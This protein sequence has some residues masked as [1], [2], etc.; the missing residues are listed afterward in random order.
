M[1]IFYLLMALLATGWCAFS[2]HSLSG[3]VLTN[4]GAPLDGAHIHIEN[5]HGTSLPDGTYSV[6]GIATGSH[7]VVISFVGYVSLDTIVD[8]HKNE[9]LNANLKPEIIELKEVVL[10]EHPGGKDTAPI[11]KL[12]AQ[13]LEKY[14]SG[15]L[16]DALKELPGVSA[17]K[18]GTTIVKPVINGLHSS[19]VPVISN[20]VRLEDQQW[21][22]EHAPNLDVNAAGKVSVIKGAQA[23]QYGGDAVGGLVVVEPVHVQLDTLFGKTVLTADSNGRGGTLSSS[24]HKGATRGWAWNAQ[25]TL[26]YYGDREAPNY[27]LSNTG[28]REANFSG[29]VGYIGERYKLTGFYSYYSA[30]IGIAATTHIG[31]VADLVRAINSRQPILVAPFTHSINNP[32]QEVQHHLAKLNFEQDL[33]DGSALSLQYAFQQNMRKEYDLRR[34]DYADIPALDLTLATHSV[35]AD[36]KKETRDYSLKAGISGAAQHNQASPDT[37]VRP[38]IPT[39]HKYD[40]GAYVIASRSFGGLTAEA[41]LRYDFSRMDADKF[42][43]KSRWTALGYDGVY[44]N[45]IVADYGTQWLTNPKFTFHNVSGG[46]GVR[47]DFGESLSLLGNLGLAVRNPN[48]SELFSDGLHHSN[49]TIELGNLGLKKEQALKASVTLQARAAA[50]RAEVTPYLNSIRNFMYLR[51]TGVEYTTRGTFPVYSY[52][53]NNAFLTGVDLHTE[54]D[55]TH[56][57]KHTLNAA[58]VHGTNTDD[59]TPLIDM[60]PLTFSNTFRYTNTGWHGFFAEVRSEAVLTQTRYPNYDFYADVPVNGELV[61][62]LVNIST[63]PKGYHLVHLSAGREFSLGKTQASIK[64][65]QYQL[66]GL[67]QPPAPVCR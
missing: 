18:T 3:K 8:F 51:P 45:F 47:K 67:P 53:Q 43:Q 2:Q 24:L 26:K 44:D 36:W 30:T 1:R 5:L 41:G 64:F 58:Y 9:V 23:L 29:D 28:N 6:T 20:N 14:S 33:H 27:V 62:T 65:I 40:A 19:R 12:H 42:Y 17:L 22:T 32:K 56:Q 60:P 39:Y 52:R 15:S 48:P 25:G 46:V 49:A 55:I 13:T 11:Q 7:R 38:L 34:G 54:W 16:G 21:G 10:T 37:G 35:N 59:D 63:P 66:P 31:N 4:T 61:P 50:F 57:L